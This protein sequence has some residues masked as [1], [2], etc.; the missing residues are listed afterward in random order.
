MALQRRQNLV[1]AEIALTSTMRPFVSAECLSH[2]ERFC[3]LVE[4]GLICSMG[5]EG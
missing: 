3:L 1:G 5:L 4:S 2:F